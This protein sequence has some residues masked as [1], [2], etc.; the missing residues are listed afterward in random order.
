MPELMSWN[1]W[2]KWRA[3]AGGGVR[4]VRGST[5]QRWEA[6][7]WRAAMEEYHGADWQ[8]T[9]R[10]GR[11]I[12]RADRTALSE[13]VRQLFP[14]VRCTSVGSG[15]AAAPRSSTM[16]RRAGALLM[17]LDEYDEHFARV[18][19]TC[20]IGSQ[21]FPDTFTPEV[22]RVAKAKVN[23]LKT[24]FDT[25]ASGPND[26]VPPGR[27]HPDVGSTLVEMFLDRFE[28]EADAELFSPGVRSLFEAYDELLNYYE[29]PTG[30]Q[31][32]QTSRTAAAET[33]EEELLEFQR[34]MGRPSRPSPAAATARGPKGSG[35][36]EGAQFKERRTR[37]SCE[38]RRCRASR[39]RRRR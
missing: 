2:Q 15:E 7:L 19:R 31:L 10:S 14:D 5:E 29:K 24:A 18:S 32:L 27:D 28:Q 12:T 25:I 20:A 38:R 26:G 8:N 35:R 33:R 22:A 13:E 9:L 4:G 11:T 34:Q 30:R 3:T 6:H 21:V 39:G 36:P 37:R 1:K 17:D 16:L 23:L